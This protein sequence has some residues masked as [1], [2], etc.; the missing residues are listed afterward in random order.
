MYD[1]QII[2]Q[3]GEIKPNAIKNMDNDVLSIGI[4]EDFKRLASEHIGLFN[5]G[6]EIVSHNVVFY[7]EKQLCSFLLRRQRR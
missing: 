6:W 2:S 1:Y 4:N 3:A 7:Q 5:D